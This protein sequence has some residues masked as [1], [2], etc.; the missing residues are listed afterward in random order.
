MKLRL[1]TFNGKTQCI[2]AWARDLGMSKVSLWSRLARGWS[3]ERALTLPASGRPQTLHYNGKA[4]CIAAWAREYGVSY[5]TLFDR[6]QSGW[7]LER[8]LNA[9]TH[10]STFCPITHNGRTQSI[11]AWAIECGVSYVSLQRRLRAGWP[12][13]D[14]L[15]ELTI[16]ARNPL[17][18]N[19]HPEPRRASPSRLEEGRSVVAATARSGL[20]Q[21]QETTPAVERVKLDP[22][23]EW[24]AER[25]AP[26]VGSDFAQEPNDRRMQQR[27]TLAVNGVISK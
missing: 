8:A 9:K 3:L 7:S 19:E 4:Q 11:R 25:K 23:R 16:K 10:H 13:A 6:L 2:A 27:D 20:I 1:I 22:A 26:G 24:A 15:A 18:S 17:H 5:A 21:S 12:I 14:A